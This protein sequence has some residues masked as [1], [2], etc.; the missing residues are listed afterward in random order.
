MASFY[1]LVAGRLA[2]IIPLITSAGSADALKIVQTDASGKLDITLLPN[3]IGPDAVIMVASEALTAGNFVNVHSVAGVANV[4]K[5][6]GTSD[7]MRATGYVQANVASGAS[8]TIFFDDNNSSLTGLT[9]GAQ[10]LSSTV[11]GATVSTPP[12][13]VGTYSQEL[14]VA[15]SATS[16]H[17]RLGE[18]Y[19]N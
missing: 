3:G 6:I 14:G 16:I 18:S 5:A 19:P 4:R 2:R 1:D 7:A 11:A 17:V 9:V 8:A 15:T 10:W 13:A 12:T